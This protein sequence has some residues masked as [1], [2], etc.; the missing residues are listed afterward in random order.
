MMRKINLS[1]AVVMFS[2]FFSV[3]NNMFFSYNTQN[4]NNYFNCNGDAI[5]I[6]FKITGMEKA[7][8]ALVIDKTLIQSGLVLS[9]YTD[10][11]GGFCKIVV[12]D[13]NNNKIDKIIEHIRSTWKDTGYFIDAELI[14][15]KE[16]N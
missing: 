5:T 3:G 7:E 14:E 6:L 1:I 15:K 9:A 4:T 11:N 2:L 13:L 10:F 12:N 16:T 8:D